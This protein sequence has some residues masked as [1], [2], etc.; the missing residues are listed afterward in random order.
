LK[1]SPW[2]GRIRV[3]LASE[4][5][6][7][8]EGL[9]ARLGK[10]PG[11]CLTV[12]EVTRQDTFP[13]SLRR[14][15]PDVLL[16]DEDLL[17][18]LGA[19]YVRRLHA[20]SSGL[21]VLLVCDSA[22]RGLVELVIGCRFHGYLLARASRDTCLKGVHAVLRGELWLPR[23]ALAQAIYGP[24]PEAKGEGPGVPTLA[25]G[26]RRKRPLTYRE[27][28]VTCCLRKGYSNKEIAHELG[29]KED[30]VKKHLCRVFGKLGVQRRTQVLLMPHQR[31]LG[32]PGR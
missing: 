20:A 3:L 11:I 32:G 16:L 27:E 26:A 23:A 15:V 29:I 22:H 4:R 30:T 10:E 18:R 25:G 12:T 28:Q 6:V 21:R 24:R 14:L 17:E 1:N 19:E 2:A 13:A 31:G 5:A 7:L 8:R 9:G